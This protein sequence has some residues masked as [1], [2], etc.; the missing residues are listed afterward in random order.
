MGEPHAPRA[1]LVELIREAR[2]LAGDRGAALPLLLMRLELERPEDAD[3][4]IEMRRLL[5]Q[6]RARPGWRRLSARLRPRPE[7]GEAR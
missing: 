1:S 2:L 4:L 3:A 5:A 7:P 6:V